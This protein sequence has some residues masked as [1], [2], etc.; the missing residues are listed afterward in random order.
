MDNTAKVRRVDHEE[1][2]DMLEVKTQLDKLTKSQKMFIAGA[3]AALGANP[4][5][6][7]R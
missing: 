1:L 3:I 5:K 4:K 7:A 2:M 6:D